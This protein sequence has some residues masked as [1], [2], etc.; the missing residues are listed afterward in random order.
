MEKSTGGNIP[1]RRTRATTT[2]VTARLR[3]ALSSKPQPYPS[4]RLYTRQQ[5]SDLANLFNSPPSAAPPAEYAPR[6]PSASPGPSRQRGSPSGEALFLSPGSAFDTPQARNKRKS[7]TRDRVPTPP[8]QPR[9]DAYRSALAESEPWLDEP[10]SPPAGSLGP[11]GQGAYRTEAAQAYMQDGV[12]DPLAGLGGGNGEGDQGD[13][14]ARKKRTMPKIDAERL[15][16]SGC[17]ITAL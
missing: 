15:V 9:F 3:S 13:E 17:E 1:T 14:P 2:L 4:Y 11:S 7:P 6:S 16:I 10:V 8:P 5:M 12:Y